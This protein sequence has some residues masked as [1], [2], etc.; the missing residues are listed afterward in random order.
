MQVHFWH[1]DK[2]Q[3][4]HKHWYSDSNKQYI[5]VEPATMAIMC[6]KPFSCGILLLIVWN[7]SKLH[8]FQEYYLLSIPTELK[9]LAYSST[10]W[11][12]D[13][14]AS[15]WMGGWFPAWK[16][17]SNCHWIPA[18]NWSISKF[19]RSIYHDAVW[20]DMHQY[21]QLS[22]CVCHWLQIQLVLET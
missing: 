18:I 17:S 9:K 12:M 14:T 21:L 15:G 10:I 20:L 19:W 1:V 6:F 11:P 4:S 8:Y 7:L 3:L 13:I 5:A 22:C 16:V 2:W